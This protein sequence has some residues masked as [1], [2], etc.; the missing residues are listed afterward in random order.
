MEK[1]YRG[2]LPRLFTLFFAALALL[3]TSCS[4]IPIPGVD[5]P[6]ATST[7][8][9][10][11]EVT[12]EVTKEDSELIALAVRYMDVTYASV[13]EAQRLDL[14]IPEGE[15][16]FPLVV[17]I[18]GGGFETGSKSGKN[19][20][21]RT[22][23]LVSHGFAVASIN[24]RLSG[25]AIYPA[26]ILDVKTAIRFLR[27]KADEYNLDPERFGAWGSSAGG[28]LAA[29][30]GTTCGVEELEGTKLG[31]AEY[32]SCVSVVVDWFGLV[33]LLAMDAQFEGTT[34]DGGHNDRNSAE[35]RLV[36]APIQTIPELVAKTN[37]MNYLSEDDAAF[38]IQHGSRDCRVP[39]VQ[40]RLLAEALIKTIG[41]E[42]VYYEE[43]EDAGH[44]GGIYRTDE[45]YQKI[46]D[47]LKRF[48]S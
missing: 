13:S 23:L 40:S 8:V 44:G 1:E 32:S 18:H 25:E 11:K 42:K 39:P 3:L 43:I 2:R 47:F 46:L 4:A 36:G 15:G 20:K 48:L 6:T 29:L 17:I 9:V 41:E 38:F 14:F 27:S 22:R 26:Q 33:D 16:P 35:S 37:P 31:Y 12:A 19:E 21:E 24:Y 7:E 30:L 5:L 45:N 10:T 34:C 28:T